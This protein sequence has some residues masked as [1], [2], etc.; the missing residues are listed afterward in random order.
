MFETL[1]DQIKNDERAASSVTARMVPWA[2]GILATV[3][4][5]GALCLAMRALG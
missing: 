4:V 2:V 3:L 5:L 1:D